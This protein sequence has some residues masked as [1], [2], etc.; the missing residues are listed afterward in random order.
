MPDALKIIRIITEI[1][2]RQF[3]FPLQ[4]RGLGNLVSSAPTERRDINACSSNEVL[5]AFCILSNHNCESCLSDKESEE[6][7]PQQLPYPQNVILLSNNPEESGS[8]GN[9]HH[10]FSGVLDEAFRKKISAQRH[11]AKKQNRSALNTGP[12]SS[13]PAEFEADRPTWMEM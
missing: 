3:F 8:N 1:I 13:T 2:L 10:E 7:S 5:R 4:H 9:H 6:H 12:H 11:S